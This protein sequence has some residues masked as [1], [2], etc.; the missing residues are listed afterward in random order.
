[1]THNELII[2]EAR[3]R[4]RHDVAE[5]DRLRAIRWDQAMRTVVNSE[6][7]GKRKIYPAIVER[8]K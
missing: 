4:N 1:M 2:A 5:A 3:A 7:F 8:T 6:N